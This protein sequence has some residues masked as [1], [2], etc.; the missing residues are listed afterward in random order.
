MAADT[1]VIQVTK[2][3]LQNVVVGL[4]FCPFAKREVERETIHYAVSNVCSTPEALVAVL[5]EA[6]R[7]DQNSDIETTLI[8]FARGF[9]DF[10][11]YLD[12][13]EGANHLLMQGGYRGIYQLAS[14]HPEYCFEGANPD[15]AA[16]YTNRSPCPMLHLLRE[17][18]L[19]KAVAHHPDPEGIPET[20]IAKAESMGAEALKA[21]LVNS[22]GSGP[23]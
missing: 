13:L 12:M 17:A 7:L 10:D 2:N 21:L 6:Q 22:M 18:S 4:N 20:N 3:W 9:E 15:D 8:I 1:Q 23:K 16:N 5:D 14:F 11:Q 19:E